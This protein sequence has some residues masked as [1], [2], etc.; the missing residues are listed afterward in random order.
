MVSPSTST[1]LP[2]PLPEPH[3]WPPQ[4]GDYPAGAFVSALA[5]WPA[6]DHLKVVVL[7]AVRQTAG[8]LGTIDV[9]GLA[10]RLERTEHTTTEALR[11][12][13]DDGWLT[14]VAERSTETGR[15]R[16]SYRLTAPVDGIWGP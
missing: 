10:A 4:T 2:D 16:T 12:L 8:G 7:Q 15:W 14:A 1:V 11:Q 3:G 9:P 6:A 13:V 5:D